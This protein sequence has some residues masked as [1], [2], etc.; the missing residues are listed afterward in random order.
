MIS[1][2]WLCLI[3]KSAFF[4]IKDDMKENQSDLPVA[5]V[6]LYCCNTSSIYKLKPHLYTVVD[7][8]LEI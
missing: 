7:R 1:L 8:Q 4:G 6:F 5:K 2:D 3:K